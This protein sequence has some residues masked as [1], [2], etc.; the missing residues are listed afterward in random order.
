M[1]KLRYI[2]FETYKTL[3][4]IAHR[5]RCG[6]TRARAQVIRTMARTGCLRQAA[7][8]AH[9]SVQ[10]ARRIVREFNET[11]LDSLPPKKAK[12]RPHKITNEQADELRAYVAQSPKK[13]GLPWTCWSLTKVFEFATGKKLIPPVAVE[14]LRSTLRR[15]G[16]SYQRTKTWKESNDPEFHTKWCRV[17]KLYAE[18]PEDGVVVCVDEFGPIEVRPQL[19]A[20]WSEIKRPNRVRATYHRNQGVRYLLAFYDVHADILDGHIYQRK[21]GEE[22]LDFLKYLRGLYPK[23]QKIY[24]VLDNFSPHRRRDIKDWVADHAMELVFIATN[25]SW[26]NRIECHFKPLKKFAISNTDPQD[27]EELAEN[28]REYMNWRNS[29]PTDR[30][31][32]EEQA[33]LKVA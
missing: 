10:Y 15:S 4:K 22:F 20:T 5:C 7:E 16:I 6:I 1:L 32:L 9:V 26:M 12:G 28:I 19:G 33:K 2:D 13:Y 29:N 3:G 8:E 31:I 21:R 18:Q 30:K 27:H 25:A 11:G 24:V 17:K 23:K 14:T